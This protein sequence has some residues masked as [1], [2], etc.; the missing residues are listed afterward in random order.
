M[1][2]GVADP[3]PLLSHMS[4]SQIVFETG[5]DG[6]ALITLPIVAAWHR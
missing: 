1:L 3:P 6:I 5:D 2:V 4:Y